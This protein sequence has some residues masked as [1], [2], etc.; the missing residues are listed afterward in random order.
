MKEKWPI[1]GRDAVCNMYGYWDTNDRFYMV[2]KSTKHPKYPD[3]AN[4]KVTRMEILAAILY[5]E[6][7]NG[8]KDTKFTYILEFDFK[9]SLPLG[10]LRKFAPTPYTENLRNLKKLMSD[11]DNYVAGKMY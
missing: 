4:K 10:I 2:T 11:P 9:G 8:G 5:L 1:G 3:G 7:C 6:P